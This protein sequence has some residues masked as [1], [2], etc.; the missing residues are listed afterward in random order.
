MG[1]VGNSPELYLMVQ[2]LPCGLA[3][4]KASA[5]LR[6]DETRGI[7]VDK[8]KL[9]HDAFDNVPGP[10]PIIFS[11]DPA[12][13]SAEMKASPAYALECMKLLLGRLLATEQITRYFPAFSL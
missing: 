9:D 12:K 8:R 7:I 6:K 3:L 10:V 2:A 11:E 5:K 13:T 4:I 1:C